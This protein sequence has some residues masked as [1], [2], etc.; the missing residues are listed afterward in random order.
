M[1]EWQ[2]LNPV[3]TRPN[4]RPCRAAW[5]AGR[6]TLSASF[7]QPGWRLDDRAFLR[8]AMTQSIQLNGEK[9]DQ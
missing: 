6:E 9:R 3:Y 1:N 2:P 5:N 7:K 4:G 8:H